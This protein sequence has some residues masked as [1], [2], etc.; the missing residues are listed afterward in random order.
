[1]AARTNSKSAPAKAQVKTSKATP[2]KAQPE[3]SK[4]APAPAGATSGQSA[5][6]T[7]ATAKSEPNVVSVKT[8]RG[9]PRHRRSNLNFGPEPRDIDL[10][11]LTTDQAQ[12]IK[13][14]PFLVV[15]PVESTAD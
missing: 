10:S 2:E 15:E 6:K 11:E 4:E 13:D 7:A 12:A 5:E 3:A 1:M 9:K 8:V 14:D